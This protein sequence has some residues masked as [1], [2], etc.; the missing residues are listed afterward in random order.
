LGDIETDEFKRQ[1]KMMTEKLQQKGFKVKF[2]QIEKRNHFDVILDLG[3]K[4]SW[5]SQQT[6]ALMTSIE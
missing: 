3:E 5:L 1:S 4:S 2:K 6:I